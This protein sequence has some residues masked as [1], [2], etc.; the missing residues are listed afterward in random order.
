MMNTPA[1]YSAVGERP[2]RVAFVMSNAIGDTLV[3]MVIV[4][5][6]LRSGI[7]VTVFGN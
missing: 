2:K 1:P 5:N 6:L 3:S 4:Q 7:E